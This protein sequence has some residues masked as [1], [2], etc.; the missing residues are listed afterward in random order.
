MPL[1]FE[2]TATMTFD[3]ARLLIGNTTIL[4]PFNA[5]EEGD[6]VVK[7]VAFGQKIFLL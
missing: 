4:Y 7:L 5:F 6:E 3:D 1:V 2:D